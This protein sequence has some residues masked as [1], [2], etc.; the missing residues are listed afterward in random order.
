MASKLVQDATRSSSTVQDYPWQ[1]SSQWGLMISSG[2]SWANRLSSR[3]H[4]ASSTV[5]GYPGPTSLL[6]DATGASSK[7]QDYP[8]TTSS[9]SDS[10]RIIKHCSGLC[11]AHKLSTLPTR[12]QVQFR[13]M[14]SPKP[15]LT[16]PLRL[17]VQ[18]RI[19]LGPLVRL[20]MPLGSTSTVQDYAGSTSSAQD[21]KQ[22]RLMLSPQAQ[23]KMQLGLL[24]D[25]KIKLEP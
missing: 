15:Q 1:T 8:G 12:P 9:A 4:R 24:V 21:I 16:M 23:L 3:H 7:V 13:I 11:L 14:L 5:Q 22:F 10:T 17:Q 25:F 20:K 6:Q 18:F 19:M 2:L